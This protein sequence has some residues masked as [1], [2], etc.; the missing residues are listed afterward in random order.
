VQ[1]T[2]IAD[3]SNSILPFLRLLVC[4]TTFLIFDSFDYVVF[5]I[6]EHLS[7]GASKMQTS[8]RFSNSEEQA[9]L[10]N[11]GPYFWLDDTAAGPQNDGR[12]AAI[13]TRWFRP[14][15]LCRAAGFFTVIFRYHLGQWFYSSFLPKFSLS[16]LNKFF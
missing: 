4:N 13:P 7:M 3:S 5:S 9:P 11:V 8:D 6:I 16:P 12:T 1:D 10:W 14:A 2:L 15:V